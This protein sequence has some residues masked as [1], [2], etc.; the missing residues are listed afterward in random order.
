[1]L[2]I[3]DA[4]DLSTDWLINGDP[5]RLRRRFTTANSASRIVVLPVRRVMNTVQIAS[6]GGAV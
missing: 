6:E 5:A 2:K 3:S 4:F 1:L